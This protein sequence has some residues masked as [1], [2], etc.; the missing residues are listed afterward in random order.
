[1]NKQF[2]LPK[3]PYKY[4]ALEPY[5]DARTMEIHYTKHHQTY[6]D[7]LNEAVA[8]KPELQSKKVEELIADLDQVP[9]SIRV[10]VKNHGGGHANHSFFWPL[11][12]KN[13]KIGGKIKEAVDLEFGSFQKF[14]EQ[15]SVA[16]LSQFGSGWAWLVVGTDGKLE[17]IS[18]ANQ[19]S[20]I[21]VG[22][23]PILTID[24]WEHAYYLK[25]QN[26]R[27]EYVEAFFNVINWHRVDELYLEKK[28]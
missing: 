5:I 15:F 22:K 13:V 1:M 24:I 2:V 3:L 16:A 7:K 4:D 9:A 10:A 23:Q 20:P 26:R 12:K 27:P 11:L 25:Y 6:V 8:G 18:T 28:K 19:D 17:I 21:S 14:K